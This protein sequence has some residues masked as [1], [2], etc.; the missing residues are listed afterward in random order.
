MCRLKYLFLLAFTALG[1]AASAQADFQDVDTTTYNQYLRK[2]WHPLIRYGKKAEKHGFDYYYL[3]MRMGIAHYNQ[4]HYYQAEKYLSKALKNNPESDDAKEL[5]F[6]SYYLTG[7]E[8]D[9][10]DTYASMSTEGQQRINYHPRRLL[11]SIYAEGGAKI[12]DNTPV[13]K[14]IGYLQFGL[15]HKFSPMFSIYHAYTFQTQQL[16]WG[17]YVQH[18]YYFAPSVNFKKHLILNIDLHYSHYHGTLDFTDH[19]A[20]APVLPAFPPPQFFRELDV[21]H[22]IRKLGTYDE[23]LLFGQ[24][25]LSKTIKGFTINPHAGMFVNF[26]KPDYTDSHTDTFRI[27]FHNRQLIDSIRDSIGN[28]VLA[29][30]HETRYEVIFGA[31]LSYDFGRFTLGAD[32]N[33]ILNNKVKT[34]TVTPWARL[35]L[36]KKA[37]LRGFFM[38][39]SNYPLALYEGSQLYNSMDKIKYKGSLTAE[40]YASKKLNLYLTYQFEGITDS[41]SDRNYNLHSL[42]IGINLKL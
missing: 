3:D 42:L 14:T 35:I 10:A 8:K 26:L 38:Y 2:A 9:A 19:K 16:Q 37:A 23:D 25:S 20:D 29:H 6:W 41:F 30:S 1:L 7:A 18:Q 4:F 34:A 36:C 12:S 40:I 24:V 22:L 21:S 27:L 32:V 28:G 17:H 11:E 15:N 39:K 33:V 5:L 31:N 13:A